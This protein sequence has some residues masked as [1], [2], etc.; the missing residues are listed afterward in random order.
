MEYLGLSHG[1]VCTNQKHIII[2]SNNTIT[3]EMEIEKQMEMKPNTYEEIDA[4]TD[5]SVDA[6][7]NA[8]TNTIPYISKALRAV[9]TTDELEHLEK[10]RQQLIERTNALRALRYC[11]SKSEY[12]NTAIYL[13]TEKLCK[14]TR[15]SIKE[16][17]DGLRRNY[18]KKYNIDGTYFGSAL[19]IMSVLQSG[20]YRNRNPL[21]KGG[22]GI[23]EF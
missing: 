22:Y 3:L 12:M 16:F 8:S 20:L 9:L 4:D 10:L 21:Q 11:K 1:L 6:E 14:T 13:N 23:I 18:H 15:A 2:T 5:I 19:K 7:T 17:I